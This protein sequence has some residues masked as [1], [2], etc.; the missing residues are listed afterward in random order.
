MN[1]FVFGSNGMLGRYVSKYLSQYYNIINII[2]N[3]I[4]ASI[5]NEIDLHN[6]LI[7]L[8]ANK[9]DVIINCIG[10]IK[11]MVDKL[12]DINSIMVNS[13]FPRTLSNVS[14][15]I[16]TNLIHP[17]TDCVFS[18][19]KG[20]YIE[21]D[22]HDVSNIDIYARTK[23]LGEPNDCTLIRTSIIGEEINQNRSLIEW[24]KNNK[25]KK[26]SGYLNHFWNG[27]TC[28]EFAK[29]CHTLIKSQKYWIGV[30][31]IYSNAINKY[32]L[33]TLINSSYNLGIE[34][35]P[36][37]VNDSVDRTL[38]SIYNNEKWI[39]LG[40]P[41]IIIPDLKTQIKEMKHF[42]KILEK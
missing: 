7:L 36:V 2:R 12:G 15:K 30:R 41:S 21:T 9:N 35:L 5:I 8:G 6:K 20:L 23:S 38:S 24:I 18:G 17:T 31:H 29:I 28:L 34:I 19:Q 16:G 25:N 26:I 22:N 4:D 10:T 13:V 40:H 14:K 33:T 1:I 11:P 42:R 39:E 37:K 27:I 3:D 32:E